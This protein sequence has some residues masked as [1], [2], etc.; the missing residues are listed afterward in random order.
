MGK[1]PIMELHG[2]M[3][4]QSPLL[5]FQSKQAVFPVSTMRKLPSIDWRRCPNPN[6]AIERLWWP[7]VVHGTKPVLAPKTAAGKPCFVGVFTAY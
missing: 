6:G 5:L 7:M 4:G 3:R 1:G 2:R